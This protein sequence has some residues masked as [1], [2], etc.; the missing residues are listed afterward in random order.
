MSLFGRWIVLVACLIGTAPVIAADGEID[1][2]LE[3][4]LAVDG[5][6]S[7]S[8]RE[9]RLQ[10]EGYANAL[11]DEAVQSA[12][13]SGPLGKIAVAMMVWSDAAFKKFETDWFI[14]DS[15]AAA[16]RYADIVE[17]FHVHSGRNYG[18]GGGGTGIGS[19]IEYALRMLDENGIEATRRTVDVSGDGVETAPWFRKAMVLPE[20]RA[21]AASKDV[22]INGLA[23]LTDFRALDR[24]Y[25]DE[26]ITGPGAFV[27]EAKD[28][29]AFAEAIQR[30]LFLE[31]MS[32]IAEGKT[33]MHNPVEA[34]LHAFEKAPIT[35]NAERN[36]ARKA[37]SR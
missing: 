29:D 18:V 2:D 19:G 21:L 27:I 12:A 11:R 32:P 13:V 14:I 20:A 28:F 3:I 22:T 35:I 15:R 4:V 25:E 36:P 34:S 1:V 33:P 6:G 16:G 26:M 10:L 23:I 17:V 24:Y 30:K 37:K 8:A 9:F 31:F 5:S 7:I